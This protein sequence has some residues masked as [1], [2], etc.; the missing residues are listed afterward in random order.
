MTHLRPTWPGCRRLA[1]IWVVAAI[2]AGC[3]PA[4]AEYDWDLSAGR[5]WLPPLVAE[6]DQ[7]ARAATRGDLSAG[8]MA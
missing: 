3:G 1:V 4:H 2:G 7:D 5:P 8:I 6:L